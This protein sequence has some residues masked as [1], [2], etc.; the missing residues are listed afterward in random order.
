MELSHLKHFYLVARSGGFTKAA[1]KN[2]LQ[3]PSLSRSV[4]LLEESLGVTLLTRQKRSVCLTDVGAEIF[5]SCEILF[6]EVEKISELAAG[7]TNDC[8]GSLKFGSSSAVAST[9]LSKVTLSF[10][11]KYPKVKPM[12]FSETAMNLVEKIHSGDLEFGLLFYVPKLP[13][14]LEEKNLVSVEFKVVVATEKAKDRSVMTS[15]YQF[16]RSG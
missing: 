8:R 10:L 3:Q 7:G 14:V 16:P 13:G 12:I 15:F 9:V 5:N 6:R 2:R 1:K 4:R 11:A